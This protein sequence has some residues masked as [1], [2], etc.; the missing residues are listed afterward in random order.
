M[1]KTFIGVSLV[2]HISNET[3]SYL[4]GWPQGGS[5]GGKGGDGASYVFYPLYWCILFSNASNNIIS[6]TFAETYDP[7]PSFQYTGSVRPVYPLSPKRP[8]PD[9]IPKPEWADT[10][11]GKEF[12]IGWLNLTIPICSNRHSSRGTNESVTNHQ[13]TDTQRAGYNAWSLQ[14]KLY[15]SDIRSRAWQ[16]IVI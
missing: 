1:L 5:C 16:F 12:C 2:F 7:F 4:E 10:T 13:N 3:N 14:G 11:Q 8:I 9:G 15:C 6:F